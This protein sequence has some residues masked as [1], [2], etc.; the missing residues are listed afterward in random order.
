MTEK[1]LD[2]EFDYTAWL[3]EKYEYEKKYSKHME[4]S[5][6]LAHKH[7][8]MLQAMLSFAS[9]R[10]SDSEKEEIKKDLAKMEKERL[11]F[12]QNTKF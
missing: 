12:S 11:E 3:S 2:T 9:F 10:L 7:I 8:G 5:D 1:K 4:E 6:L